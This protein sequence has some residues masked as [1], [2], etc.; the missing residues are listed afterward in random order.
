MRD[1]VGRPLKL[2]AIVLHGGA[3]PVISR[4]T[5]SPIGEA[6][7]RVQLVPR[8]AGDR[9]VLAGGAAGDRVALGGEGVDALLAR[10][11]RRRARVRRGA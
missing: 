4:T 11:D 7:A 1:E 10:T 3:G 5:T 2:A 6:L 8:E 9:Q